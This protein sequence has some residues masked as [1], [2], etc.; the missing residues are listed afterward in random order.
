MD[1]FALEAF[2]ELLTPI[3]LELF[4]EFKERVLPKSSLETNLTLIPRLYKD[5]LKRVKHTLHPNEYK[6]ESHQGDTGRQNAVN[7]TS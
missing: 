1:G 2:G 3:L 4:N 5:P 7:H 6:H